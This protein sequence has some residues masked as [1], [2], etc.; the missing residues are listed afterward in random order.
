M[1]M[2]PVAVM[3]APTE[4]PVALVLALAPAVIAP[5]VASTVP[6]VL[7]IETLRPLMAAVLDIAPPVDFKTMSLPVVEMAALTVM[8]LAAEKVSA[9]LVAPE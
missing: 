6:P 7:S 8:L 2:L 1:L 3:L 9:G 5:V 4:T